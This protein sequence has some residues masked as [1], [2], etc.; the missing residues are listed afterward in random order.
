MGRGSMLC[1]AAA[2]PH[3]HRSKEPAPC[4]CHRAVCRHPSVLLRETVQPS[5]SLQSRA[6]Q[7]LLATVRSFYLLGRRCSSRMCF[8]HT[9]QQ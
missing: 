2:A 7:T 6:Q 1:A 4:Q 3:V 8:F 9:L 5:R